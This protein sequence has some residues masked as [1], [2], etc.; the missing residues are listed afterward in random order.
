MCALGRKE[1]KK[2]K[3]NTEENKIY[4]N[5][6]RKVREVFAVLKLF[7]NPNLLF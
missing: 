7:S 3:D 1:K 2:N 4:I 6:K 5:K